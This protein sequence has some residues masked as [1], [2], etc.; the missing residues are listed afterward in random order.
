MR[1]SNKI[2]D[3]IEL[4]DNEFDINEAVELLRDLKIELAME[5]EIG[6]S[7]TKL[8][9]RIKDYMK[10]YGEIPDVDGV[11]AKITPKKPTLVIKRGQLTNLYAY[12]S[13]RDDINALNYFEEK[14][15]APAISLRVE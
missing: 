7:L 3:T 10:L 8:E 14:Q 11:T 4:D 6:R 13:G 9:K 2:S 1:V 15:Y 5:L 12:L